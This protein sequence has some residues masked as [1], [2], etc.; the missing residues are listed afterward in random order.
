MSWM[1]QTYRE[2][3]LCY[4]D[5]IQGTAA[6]T[7]AAVLGGLRLQKP[8]AGQVGGGGVVGPLARGSPTKVDYRKKGTLILTSLLEDLGG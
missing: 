5:D 7:V 2:Q 6:V 8:G 4:N 3:Y 1:P